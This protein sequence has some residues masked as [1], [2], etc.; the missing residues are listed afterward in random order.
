MPFTESSGRSFSFS[1][2]VLMITTLDLSTCSRLL[3]AVQILMM[4][5]IVLVTAEVLSSRSPYD[6]RGIYICYGTS[7]DI[8]ITFPMTSNTW[9]S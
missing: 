5:M 8:N 7:T 6:V 3:L 4:I 9:Y 2:E 1:A